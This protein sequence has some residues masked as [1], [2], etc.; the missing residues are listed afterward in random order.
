MVSEKQAGEPRYSGRG[1]GGGWV[2]GG[3]VGGDEVESGKINSQRRG[4]GG[5][6]GGVGGVTR[7]SLENKLTEEGGGVRGEGGGWV[8]G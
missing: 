8:G 4:G 5:A 2:R 1:G 7:W 6:W 3:G